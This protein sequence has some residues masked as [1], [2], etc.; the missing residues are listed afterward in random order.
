MVFLL[1]LC[2]SF[3]VVLMMVRITVFNNFVF[4]KGSYVLVQSV[5]YSADNPRR[6]LM[7]SQNSKW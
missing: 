2:F 5:L 1:I 4:S 3:I 6:F 7:Y